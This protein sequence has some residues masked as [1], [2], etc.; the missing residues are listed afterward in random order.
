MQNHLPQ[1]HFYR[2]VLLYFQV[3]VLI[4]EVLALVLG[5]TCSMESTCTGS[6]CNLPLPCNRCQS[7]RQETFSNQIWFT[8]QHLLSQNWEMLVNWVADLSRS[9]DCGGDVVFVVGTFPSTRSGRRLRLRN[10][11]YGDKFFAKIGER[12]AKIFGWK[13]S[14]SLQRWSG[15]SF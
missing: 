10:R 3:L 15:V 2:D 13:C 12:V 6:T 8:F 14:I 7:H 11:K 9:L 1:K 5:S 4:Q